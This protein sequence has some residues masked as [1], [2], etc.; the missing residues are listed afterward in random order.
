MSD[1]PKDLL[2]RAKEF[3]VKVNI[4]VEAES[5]EEASNTVQFILDK[6]W[7]TILDYEVEEIK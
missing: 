2:E 1:I 4:T 5:E 7:N 3:T 6:R